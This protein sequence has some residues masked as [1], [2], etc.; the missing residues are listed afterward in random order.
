MHEGLGFIQL[1]SESA[2]SRHGVLT[3]RGKSDYHV[4]KTVSCYGGADSL[5]R[6]ERSKERV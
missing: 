1:T 5:W 4:W 3:K 2:S 6:A